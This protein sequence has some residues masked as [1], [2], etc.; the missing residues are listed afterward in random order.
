MIDAI[1][2]PSAF[3]PITYDGDRAEVFIALESP[4]GF[5]KSTLAKLLARRWDG[6]VIH[7]LDTPHDEWSREA[8]TLKPLP[9][10]AFYLSGLLNVSDRARQALTNGPVIADRYTSS[11]VAC[12]AAIHGATTSEVDRLLLPFRP[13]LVVPDATFYLRCTEET[14]RNRLEQKPDYKQ[15]DADLFGIPGRFKSLVESFDAVAAQDPTAV[16][17]ETDGLT[18]NDLVH[19]ITAH[20]ET[21]RA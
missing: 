16:M 12:Q 11:V 1:Q 20:M 17:L 15:D 4:S 13:Y 8:G 10:F 14:L 2:L 5:G 3:E 6:T 21:I 18:P 9:Q 7:T 19:A